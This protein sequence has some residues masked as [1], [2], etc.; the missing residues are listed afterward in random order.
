MS[1]LTTAPA[2]AESESVV[3]AKEDGDDQ[4]G[5]VE[6]GEDATHDPQFKPLVKLEKLTTVT[7]G[8]E[9][10]TA[11][12][13]EHPPHRDD[14]ERHGHASEREPRRPRLAERR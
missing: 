14:R 8:E 10:W 5:T 12:F 2:L 3:S 13:E 7:T 11:L 6:G 1:A 4:G 9:G